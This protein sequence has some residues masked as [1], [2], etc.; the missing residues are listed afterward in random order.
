VLY[1]NFKISIHGENKVLEREFGEAYEN[2]RK[3][4]NEIIPFPVIRKQ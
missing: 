4:V 3:R 1:L 2:Y